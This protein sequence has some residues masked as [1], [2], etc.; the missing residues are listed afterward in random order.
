MIKQAIA[1]KQWSDVI[2][3]GVEL[4]QIDPGNTG[5]LLVLA[6]TSARLHFNEVE[7]AYLKQAL[8]SKPRGY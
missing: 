3:L 1:N 2:R 5:S 7:L 6:E 8:D 4:I